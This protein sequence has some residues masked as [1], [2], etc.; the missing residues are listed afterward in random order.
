MVLR[1]AVLAWHGT[2]PKTSEESAAVA[3]NNEKVD[4][5][6]PQSECHFSSLAWGLGT[7]KSKELFDGSQDASGLLVAT[8]I[9]YPV[10]TSTSKKRVNMQAGE[11]I[12][13]SRIGF[14]LAL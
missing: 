3:G 13:D 11:P 2:T 5:A 12:A 9:P 7:N 1:L 8:P 14:N 6:I 4:C 10:C